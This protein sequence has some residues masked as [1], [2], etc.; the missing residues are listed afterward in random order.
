ML[1]KDVDVDKSKAKLVQ[2]YK[3]H[4]ERVFGITLSAWSRLYDQAENGRSDGDGK[5]STFRMSSE[6]SQ[7]SLEKA[8]NYIESLTAEGEEDFERIVEE[9]SQEELNMVLE[10]QNIIEN[11]SQ[12]VLEFIKN[13][14]DI[15]IFGNCKN[16]RIAHAILNKMREKIKA[17]ES[18]F[19]MQDLINQS[20]FSMCSVDTIYSHDK[21]NIETSQTGR[22]NILTERQES[23][24]T[25][26]CPAESF[27]SSS[28]NFKDIGNNL[29]DQ[30]CRE[31]VFSS[32]DEGDVTPDNESS[33][34]R[35]SYNYCESFPSLSSRTQYS[36]PTPPLPNSDDEND[37]EVDRIIQDTKNRAQIEFA[38]KLGYS[39]FEIATVL[40]RL[41]PDVSQNEMLSEL[42]KVGM[43][44]SFVADNGESETEE[45][46]CSSESSVPFL[47]YHDDNDFN[48]LR[49]IVIDGSNVAMSHGNKEVFSCHGI[50]LAVD[51]FRQ[52]GHTQITVFVPQWRKESSRPDARITDQDILNQLEKEKTLVFTP[53]RRIG[54]KRVVCYDDRYVLKLAAE[55]DGVVVSNDNY[56]DLIN[57]KPEYKKVVEERLLMFSFVNDRFMPPDDP[58]GRR[59]PSLDNF[60]SRQPARSQENLPPPCP[61]GS[62]KC[63]YGNKCKYYHPERGNIPQKSVTDKLAEHAKQ[64]IQVVRAKAEAGAEKKKLLARKPK[65]ALQRTKSLATELPT[66]LISSKIDKDF[67]KLS[68]E[69]VLK[70]TSEKDDKWKQYDEKLTIHR[71]KLEQLEQEEQVRQDEELRRQKDQE[72]LSTFSGGNTRS[73]TPSPNRLS[74]SPI[75][76]QEQFLSGHLLLAKKLS[77]EANDSKLRRTDEHSYTKSPLAA[78]QSQPVLS[79]EPANPQQ[80]QHKKLSRQYSLQ[81]AQDP[82]LKP[83]VRPQMSYD[84]SMMYKQ[85]AY[86]SGPYEQSSSQYSVRHRPLDQSQPYKTEEDHY[87]HSASYNTERYKPRPKESEG[88]YL[89]PESQHM[90]LA[91]MQS[92]PEVI[93]HIREQSIG[94]PIGKM[95]RQNSSSDTQLHIMGGETDPFNYNLFPQ[96]NVER[97]S[98]TK[99]QDSVTYNIG[100]QMQQEQYR[101]S[102]STVG[103]YHYQ[104]D[105]TYSQQPNL[106]PDPRWSFP[107]QGFQQPSYSIGP[108]SDMRENQPFFG[109]EMSHDFTSLRSR[110]SQMWQNQHNI[111]HSS[112]YAGPSNDPFQQARHSIPSSMSS[113][114]F[115]H[116]QSQIST[117]EFGAQSRPMGVPILGAQSVVPQTYQSIPPTDKRYALYYHLCALFPEPKVRAVMNQFPDIDNPQELC[118]Y[119]I[120]AK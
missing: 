17:D 113:S 79:Q 60:L 23:L 72:Y 92:A 75:R 58:L 87:M 3:N 96:S 45:T 5:M 117:E 31:N 9:L 57:E 54:G 27:I 19:H 89:S 77:D 18:C 15:S 47:S 8:K 66:D 90:S 11:E 80:P 61:Y 36:D 63:T 10:N 33:S 73:N 2:Q 39:E 114:D 120:G 25:D 84:P 34:D 50:Q 41:Q 22:N 44:S 68:M 78:T 46:Y 20:H 86:P 104:G 7:E 69:D 38:L 116:M 100:G 16:V 118:A 35:F 97:S 26:G 74:P 64:K 43:S 98:I 52:R 93:H 111:R 4:I 107:E 94:R 65:L 101:R 1:S 109:R 13:S 6:Y 81:G 76:P 85:S 56:R 67:Q 28:D 70:T 99:R 62:K 59:G 51:W 32:P 40:K 48:N 110:G 82:R 102:S 42:I 71:R 37:V 49:P 91:R 83:N 53:A 112:S 119:L 24:Q 95:M 105:Q 108:T 12:A 55:N 88:T 30:L 14:N 106:S 115:H 29:I 103:Q 21:S